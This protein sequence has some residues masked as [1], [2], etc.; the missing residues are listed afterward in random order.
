MYD[1]YCKIKIKEA[2]ADTP[3][4][5]ISGPRQSGKTTLAKQLQSKNCAYIT[6]DDLTQYDAA[7]RDP[8]NFIRGLDGKRIIIDEVQRVPELFLV[9]KQSVDE[10][11][12]PGQFLLTGSSNAFMLPTVADSLAGRV[13]VVQLLPLTTCEINGVPSTFIDKVFNGEVPVTKEV[14]VRKQLIKKILTGGFPEPLARSKQERRVVWYQQYIRSIIQK[15]LND[16]G[17]IL[18]VDV[19]PK[20]VK[21]LAEQVAQLKNYNEIAGKLGIT[22][23]TVSHYTSLLEQLYMFDHLPAWHKS[24]SKRL[25]K[26]PKIHIVDS[27]LLCALRRL[28]EDKLLENFFLYGPLLENYVVNEIK[29]LATWHKEWIGFYHYRD[30]DQVEVDLILE[31]FDGRVVGLEVKASSTVTGK[32]FH[33]LR[34]LQ[35][36]VGDKFVMGLILYDGDHSTQHADR[37][38][39]VPVGCLWE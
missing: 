4:V 5:V 8:I 9:I 36:L 23:H 31:D 30:K 7:K 39:S 35:A 25:V 17:N 15:D 6:L 38:Y 27:G 19:M 21:L 2:L 28:T 13:E 24:E 18:H 12:I 3:V 32:D 37:L 26:T 1:R 34:K 14:R 11:R 29:R 33:G 20:L 22:R 16:I 10:K